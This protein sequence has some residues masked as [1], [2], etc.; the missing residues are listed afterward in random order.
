MPL[1]RNKQATWERRIHRAKEL[2]EIH[3]FASEVLSFYVEIASFQQAICE[4][5]ESARN[6]GVPREFVPFGD[7]LDLSAV[8]PHVPELLALVARV[9]PSPLSEAAEELKGEDWSLW[10]YLLSSY[11]KSEGHVVEGAPETHLFFARALLQPYAEHFAVL[12]NI[13]LPRFGP[14]ACPICTGKPQV[15]VLREEGHGAK[16]SL[17]C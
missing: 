2:A 7:C 1:P 17:V 15:G 9:A 5:I 12:S 4:G 16:R 6:G 3:P 10:E 11:W 8:L 13:E 14:P